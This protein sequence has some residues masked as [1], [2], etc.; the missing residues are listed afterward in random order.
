LR[1][2]FLN[3]YRESFST[4]E[5]AFQFDAALLFMAYNQ[6]IQSQ[7]L[8]GDTL[9]IGV[10]HGLSSIAVAALRGPDRR[11]FAVDLFGDNLFGKLVSKI[12]RT[13]APGPGALKHPTALPGGSGNKDTFVRNLKAFYD[14]TDFIEVLQGNSADLKPGDLGTQFSFCHI[15]G[16]H[17]DA[18]TYHDL[19][20][21]TE[22]LLPGGLLALDDYF[23]ALYP[24]VCE[25]AVRFNLNYPGKLKPIAIGFNKVLFQKPTKAFNLN[26][27]FAETFSHLSKTEATLWGVPVNLFWSRFQDVFDLSLSTPQRLITASPSNLRAAFEPQAATINAHPKDS[28][29]LPVRVSNTSTM[30]FHC[31]NG[32]LGLSYHLLTSDGVVMQYDN[33]RAYFHDQ[34]KPGEKRLVELTILTPETCGQYLV[35]IDIVWEGI[36]WF[37]DKGNPTSIVSLIV[38]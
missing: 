31:V 4:I 33:P 37:K 35:E 29:V 30:P 14:N 12:S 20:L 3:E 6:L 11:F 21:C 36:T 23:N 9:E 13:I 1:P 34:L 38:A 15:D 25:G 22:I 2:N 28:L 8:S 19:E 18:E 24:G 10:R 17:S 27:L 16:G 7:G 5:G 32:A 26:A